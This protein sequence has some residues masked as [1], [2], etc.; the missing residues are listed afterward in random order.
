MSLL[1]VAAFAT[2]AVSYLNGISANYGVSINETQYT[3]FAE[4]DEVNQTISSLT[5][6]FVNEEGEQAED[7]DIISNMLTSSYG[8]IKLLFNLPDLFGDLVQSAIVAV[9]LPPGVAN[10]VYFLAVGFFV[11]IILFA[12]L[13][14]VMKVRA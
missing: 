13:A 4:L 9:G 11:I 14:L 6:Q 2:L 10:V 1:L 8:L 5:N 3:V 7:S 12:A